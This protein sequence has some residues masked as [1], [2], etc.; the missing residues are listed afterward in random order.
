M[1]GNDDSWRYATSFIVHQTP[2]SP[3][4]T[5]PHYGKIPYH[6]NTHTAQVLSAYFYLFNGTAN[7]HDYLNCIAADQCRIRRWVL[8]HAVSLME[9]CLYSRVA[10]RLY[11]RL[12]HP[13]AFAQSYWVLLNQLE[14][15]VWECHDEALLWADG[16][17]SC[18]YELR[19]LWLYT[20]PC[21]RYF[22]RR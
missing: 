16:K 12:S 8:Y 20:Q 14:V 18:R 10:E 5:P 13:R 3:R 21:W 9:I 19:N 17:S 7:V 2:P 4:R 1:V 6:Q 22:M 15:K 11:L